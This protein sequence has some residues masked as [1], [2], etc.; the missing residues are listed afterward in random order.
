MKQLLLLFSFAIISISS[1]AQS[2]AKD[3]ITTL[4][5]E[6][7][8]EA[9]KTTYS[10]AKDATG[11]VYNDGKSLVKQIYEDGKSLAPDIKSAFK[12]LAD[13]FNT[14]VNKL[15]D[16]LVLQQYVWSTCYAIIL[17]LTIF[18][19]VKFTSMIAKTS[20]DLTETKEMKPLNI[21]YTIILF[22]LAI[23]GTSHAGE[24][25]EKMLTGFINPEFGAVRTIVEFI[26]K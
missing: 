22:G 8:S 17:L 20:K 3:E 2:S 5:K 1:S 14:T 13:G 19:W 24:N 7:S 23:W 26:Q 11:V 15:W 21:I 25:I 10:D 6:Q 18:A 16:I 12:S 9:V 4:V